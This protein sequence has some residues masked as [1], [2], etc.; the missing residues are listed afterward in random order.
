VHTIYRSRKTV[1]AV[2]CVAFLNYVLLQAQPTWLQQ[3]ALQMR[4]NALLG[5]LFGSAAACCCSCR[6]FGG[7]C[8]THLEMFFL[9][10]ALWQQ[11]SSLLAEVDWFIGEIDQ[12]HNCRSCGAADSCSCS[13]VKS[14]P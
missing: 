5:N 4:I 3:G 2:C 11:G 1:S 9:Q 13:S 8:L 14:K 7:V 6:L 10:W 12:Q